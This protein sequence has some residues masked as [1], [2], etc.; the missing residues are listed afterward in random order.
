MLTGTCLVSSA[1]LLAVTTTSCSSELSAVALAACASAGAG[2]AHSMSTPAIPVNPV[3]AVTRN[4]V[5][6]LVL[7]ITLCC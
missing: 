2:S 7:P 6:G 5:I 3:I 1:R 4:D